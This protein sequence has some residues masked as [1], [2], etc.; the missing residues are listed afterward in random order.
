MRFSSAP[1][2]SRRVPSSRL[3][4]ASE[5]YVRL[6]IEKP[7]DVLLG[8]AR[9]HHINVLERLVRQIFQDARELLPEPRPWLR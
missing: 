1:S 2:R 5:G 3:G 6:P 9:G 4:S 8:P 7:V